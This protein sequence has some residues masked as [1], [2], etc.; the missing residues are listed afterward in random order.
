[1]DAKSKKDS[2]ELVVITGLSGAGRTEAIRCFEDMGYFCVDNLPP[3]FIRNL[4]DLISLPGT[5]VHKVAVVSDVRGKEFFPQLK[6][7]LAELRKEGPAFTLVFLTAS[8]EI[9]IRRFKETRRRHPLAESGE[10]AAGIQAEREMLQEL[11]EQADLVIDT[12]NLEIYELRDK[13]RSG[14]LGKRKRRALKVSIL[15][16][17]FKYG[18]PLDADIVMDVRFLPNPHYVEEI[19]DLTG[20]DAPVQDYVLSR[21]ESGKFLED[22]TDLLIDTLPHYVAE[23]K[24]HLLI[25][26][27]CTGGQHRSVALAQEMG[28]RIKEAGYDVTVSHRDINRAE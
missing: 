7:V 3:F 14:F 24:T 18:S 9:L 2:L 17:G 23:G 25:A 12:S 1:M 16:F 15:S 28:R 11:K 22:F 4:I 8:D 5:K 10:V 27:G 13:I 21:K 20:L 19:R 26:L 6:D